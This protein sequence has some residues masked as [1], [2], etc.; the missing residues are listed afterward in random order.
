LRRKLHADPVP[1]GPLPPRPD[2]KGKSKY[3]RLTAQ[4]A[5]YENKV[6]AVLGNTVEAVKRRAEGMCR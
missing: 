4:L 3:D 5:I 1:F 2:G 6:L